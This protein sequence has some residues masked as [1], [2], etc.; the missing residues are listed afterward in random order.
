MCTVPILIWLI[1]L[2]SYV[3]HRCVYIFHVFLW[4]I[5]HIWHVY[6]ISWVYLHLAHIWQE[7]QKYVLQ[8]IVFKHICVNVLD[9]YTH[10]IGWLSKLHMK[11]C[12]HI[13]SV[14]YAYIGLRLYMELCIDNCYTH[15]PL[16]IPLDICLCT[17]MLFTL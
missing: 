17:L 13:C 5:W 9:L 10:L 7:N 3:A 4:N 8:F 16:N 14:I 2:T 11:C 1:A 15:L 12:S 6:P